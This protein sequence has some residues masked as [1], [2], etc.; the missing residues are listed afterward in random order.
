MRTVR[1]LARRLSLAHKPSS[2]AA[3]SSSPEASPID[4]GKHSGFESTA[5]SEHKPPATPVAEID[6]TLPMAISEAPG[7]TT[8][9][10]SSLTIQVDKGWKFA[11]KTGDTVS[12]EWTET[13]KF[14]TNVHSELLKL[15]KI[16]DPFVGLNEYD[17][18]C[19]YIMIP[20]TIRCTFSYVFS[21]I[22]DSL[23]HQGSEKRIG[24]SRPNLFSTRMF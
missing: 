18:Q 19:E 13:S 16:P 8:S 23:M 20:S 22:A 5:A 17:V 6:Q 1:S 9:S 10:S 12:D 14:P 11:Q 4:K 7:S 24:F 15:K 2:K 3:S 21:V